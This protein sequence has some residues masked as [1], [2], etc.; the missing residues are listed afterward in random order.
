MS[1]WRLP[2]LTDHVDECVILGLHGYFRTRLEN[3]L[4]LQYD[5]S[6]HVAICHVQMQYHHVIS[7]RTHRYAYKSQYTFRYIFSLPCNL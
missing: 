7:K 2:A 6:F 5:V 1:A 4:Y 3:V